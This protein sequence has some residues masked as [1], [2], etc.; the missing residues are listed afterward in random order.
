MPSSHAVTRFLIL[1]W[2]ASRDNT[3]SF[4]ER[5]RAERNQEMLERQFKMKETQRETALLRRQSA[6][7]ELIIATGKLEEH[8]A[9]AKRV[10]VWGDSGQTTAAA[11][12]RRLSGPHST[13]VPFT[14]AHNFFSQPPL[15]A[16]PRSN[17]N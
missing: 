7:A 2:P 11:G 1:A 5:K 16:L 8:Q 6:E 14:N 13:P 3:E 10:C 4:N 17:C 9:E 15:T 12:S